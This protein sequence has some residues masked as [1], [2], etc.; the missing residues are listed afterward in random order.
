MPVSNKPQSLSQYT[1][2]DASAPDPTRR[3]VL[4][5]LLAACTAAHIPWALAQPIADDKQGAFLAL[6]AIIVGRKSLDTGMAQ[7]LYQALEKQNPGFSEAAQ[8]LLKLINE[9]NI[10]PAQLQKT[11]D[12]K[13]SPLAPL[14][15][16]IATAWFM[17]I[18]G[19]GTEAHC[20]AYEHALN[21]QIVA[22]TLKPPTY[23]YGTYGSWSRKPT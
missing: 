16:Q 9:H 14:P 12:T 1:D 13:N 21:A 15:R 6:S 3:R 8:A 7:R 18:V 10:E 2:S 20:L 22:D 23:A 4:G 17:G 11:L 5:S 19:S